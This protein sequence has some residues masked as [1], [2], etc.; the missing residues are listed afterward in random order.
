[1]HGVMQLG[2]GFSLQGQSLGCGHL[3]WG[4]G[5]W[6]GTEVGSAESGLWVEGAQAPAPRLLWPKVLT[7]RG[8]Q[9]VRLLVKGNLPVRAIRWVKGDT[10]VGFSATIR[11][12]HVR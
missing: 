11:G 8:F 4:S 1:M 9:L 7:L 3:Y 5:P 12:Q 2:T 10:Y 6:T